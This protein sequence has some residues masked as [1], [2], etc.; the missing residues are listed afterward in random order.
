LSAACSSTAA[1]GAAAL[2]GIATDSFDTARDIYATTIEAVDVGI[3]GLPG[4]EVL[5]LSI[6][7]GLVVLF[8]ITRVPI[9]HRLLWRA[10]HQVEEGIQTHPGEYMSMTTDFVRVT[11]ILV[12]F[13]IALLAI[14]GLM[15][16][17]ELM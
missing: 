10:E 15:D 6:V 17:S 7:A 16:M 14:H 5:A 11:T 2:A 8:V 9:I 13:A 12:G 1:D 4:A 3:T